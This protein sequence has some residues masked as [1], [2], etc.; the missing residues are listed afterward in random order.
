M[1]LV[2]TGTPLRHARLVALAALAAAPLAAQDLEREARRDSPVRVS[3][4]LGPSVGTFTDAF[5]NVRGVHGELAVEVSPRDWPVALR[6]EF[7]L[8]RFNFEGLGSGQCLNNPGAQQTALPAEY[9]CGVYRTRDDVVSGTLN[10]TAPLHLG[11]VTAYAIAGA[12]TYALTERARL[13]AACGAAANC[14]QTVDFHTSWSRIGYN[15]G[16]GLTFR[17]GVLQMFAEA[18][19][20]YLPGSVRAAH[21]IPVTI[22]ITR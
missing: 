1:R 6:G 9:G 17:M 15:A 18:R 5:R 12:G 20:H 7:G 19:Y 4:S 13:L 2:M 3:L 10:V 11:P 22:G 21:M 14:V 8:H 16:G